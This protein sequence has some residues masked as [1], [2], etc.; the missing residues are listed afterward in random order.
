MLLRGA[1]QETAPPLARQSPREPGL[2]HAI[3]AGWNPGEEWSV[4]GATRQ[5]WPPRCRARSTERTQ[6][7]ARQ[8]PATWRG[9]KIRLQ[10]ASGSGGRGGGLGF[11]EK[12]GEEMEDGFWRGG[13]VL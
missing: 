3:A 6:G 12:E 9:R 4:E 11:P 7:T 5:S 13:A 2:R 1:Q 10:N 8:G